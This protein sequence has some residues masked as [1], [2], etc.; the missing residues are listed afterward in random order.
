MVKNY[1]YKLIYFKEEF[2]QELLLTGENII[3][4]L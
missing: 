3:V 2:Y 1:Y 4:K